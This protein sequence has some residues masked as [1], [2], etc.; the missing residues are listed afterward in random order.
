MDQGK[1]LPLTQSMFDTGI[2]DMFNIT[3]EDA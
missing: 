3:L 1:V 2:A